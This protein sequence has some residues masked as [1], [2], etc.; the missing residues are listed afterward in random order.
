MIERVGVYMFVGYRLRQTR[1]RKVALIT[2]NFLTSS[3]TQGLRRPTARRGQ[4]RRRDSGT[5]P[6]QDSHRRELDEDA[7]LKAQSRRRRD[8]A[9]ARH[10]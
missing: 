8:P 4:R 1:K 3:C 2:D 7:F 10:S 6:N 9:H 5:E